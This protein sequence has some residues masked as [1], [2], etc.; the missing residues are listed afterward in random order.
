MTVTGPPDDYTDHLKR[1]IFCLFSEEKTMP[2]RVILKDIEPDDFILAIR[3]ARW[4]LV[5]IEEDVF[6]K[7]AI[8]SYGEDSK[9]RNFY[10]CRNKASV[11]VRPC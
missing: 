6:R 2:T 5:E 10:V 8:L 7:D 4:M 9:R 1:A 3:A 11:T